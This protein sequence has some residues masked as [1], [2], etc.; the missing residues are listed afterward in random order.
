[1]TEPLY[2]EPDR[3]SSPPKRYTVKDDH[4]NVQYITDLDDPE[5]DKT[6]TLWAMKRGGWL[7][8]LTK[9]GT[10]HSDA[11]L[12]YRDGATLLRLGRPLYIRP[13]TTTD[14]P[15]RLL[16][17][18]EQGNVLFLTDL[19]D[20]ETNQTAT[21]AAQRLGGWLLGAVKQLQSETDSK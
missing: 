11:R 2:V 4:G 8:G 9:G 20:G 1:M 15:R 5:P 13:D 12:E 16:V 21:Q 3:T 17:T 7:K 19:H 10:L 18:D 14:P 6:A